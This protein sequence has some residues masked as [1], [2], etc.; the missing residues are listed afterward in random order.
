MT[1]IKT[2][3]EEAEADQTTDKK[4]TEEEVQ[5]AQEAEADLN[6][7]ILFFKNSTFESCKI[8]NLKINSLL[9]LLT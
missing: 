3:E 8:I 4:D 1:E 5:V 7:L 6:H 9:F 2:T